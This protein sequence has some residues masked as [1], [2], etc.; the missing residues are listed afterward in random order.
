MAAAW[1]LAARAQQ[2]KVP[3]VG[4]LVLGNPDPGPF[5]TLFREGLRDLGYIDGQT[6]LFE[7]RS[8]GGKA[9]LL[10]ELAA[11]LVR[12]KVDIIVVWHT[13]TAHAARQATHEIPIVMADVGD[14][15]G[16]GLVA[17]L[18]RP[19]GNITGLSAVTAE[20]AGKSVQFIREMMP[21]ASR[22]VAPV[23]YTHLT[24]PTILR[25]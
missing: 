10:T 16:T 11:D 25:V 20:L 12:L 22:V 13:P 14:P 2:P 21:S 9:G 7:F 1:P 24:L 15:V 5:W 8:A 17:S 4:V 18:A 6:I 23:S 3:K 19:G